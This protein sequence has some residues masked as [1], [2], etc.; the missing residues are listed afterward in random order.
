MKYSKAE[1]NWCFFTLKNDNGST[2]KKMKSK[3]EY[4]IAELSNLRPKI[5]R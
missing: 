5:L 2:E 1:K 4:A 3:F